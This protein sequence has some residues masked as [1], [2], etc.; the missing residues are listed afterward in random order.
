[1]KVAITGTT[2]FIGRYVLTELL[3][4]EVEVVAVVRTL[5]SIDAL[6]DNLEI[7]QFDL[8]TPP[9][10]VFDA[11]GEP[12][13]LLHLA[14]GGLPHYDSMHHLERELPTQ[15]NFL[16]KLIN[17]GLQSLIVTGTCFEYGMQS[18][19]LTESL[20]TRPNNPYGLAKDA[21]RR[22]LE[23]LREN[24]PFNLTWAR[25]F[26]LYGHGQSESSLMPQLQ[27]AVKQGCTAFNM[28]G[29]EQ[30]RD[31][32]PVTEVAKNLVMLALRKADVGIVNICSGKPISVHQLV[33][34]WI[35]ENNWDIK[36]NLGYYPYPDYEPMA[37]WG[38]RKKL[39][40]F[41]A[42]TQEPL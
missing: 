16:S 21:L 31:Y 38:S 13:V 32:L 33:K 12:D 26:Y 17:S 6:P 36:L 28:S 11:I 42:P 7:A 9:I 19:E 10:N 34:K 2:G 24:C 5:S 40:S 8:S 23:Q 22:N 37:F 20:K 35:N 14:W 1:V 30:L 41:L 15:C 39:D 3:K 25:L 29:G 27:R 18:G 4:C